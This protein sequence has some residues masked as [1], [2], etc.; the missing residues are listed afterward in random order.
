MDMFMILVLL[1]CNIGQYLDYKNCKCRKKLIEKLDEKCSEDINRN[2]M[3]NNMT[4]NDY[5]RV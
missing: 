3:I 5:G 2:E 4:L 1:Q